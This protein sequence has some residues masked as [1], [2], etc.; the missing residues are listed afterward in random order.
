[1]SGKNRNCLVCL[2]D[3]ASYIYIQATYMH[4]IYKLFPYNFR[5]NCLVFSDKMDLTIQI[6]IFSNV[7]RRHA[8]CLKF[9]DKFFTF[10]TMVRVWSKSQYLLCNQKKSNFILSSVFGICCRCHELTYF[11]NKVCLTK[12]RRL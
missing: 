6:K 10:L 7:K 1:M 5:W 3:V 9:G 11:N 12:K 2:W 4:T 8:I